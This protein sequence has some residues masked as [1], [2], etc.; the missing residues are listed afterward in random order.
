MLVGTEGGERGERTHVPVQREPLKWST[1]LVD[2]L[3]ENFTDSHVVIAD[4]T[5]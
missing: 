5:I 2:I 3:L 4:D 1:Q